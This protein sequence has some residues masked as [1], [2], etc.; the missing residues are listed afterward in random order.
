MTTKTIEASKLS[1]SLLATL[2][3]IQDKID[4]KVGSSSIYVSYN[5]ADVVKELKEEKEKTTLLEIKDSNLNV[6]YI[7]Y[8]TADLKNLNI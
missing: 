1:V 4:K 2:D 8:Y 7:G 5:R 6:V 3:K